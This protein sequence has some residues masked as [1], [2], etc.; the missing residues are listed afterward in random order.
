[1]PELLQLSLDCGSFL[2]LIGQ[3]K[4]A[5]DQLKQRLQG[6]CVMLTMCAVDFCQQRVLF[7]L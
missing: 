4:R 2:S 3:S 1:M 7:T 5:A 6:Q